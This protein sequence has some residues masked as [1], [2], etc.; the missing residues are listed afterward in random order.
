MR[1]RHLIVFAKPPRIGRAKRRL[2]ADIGATEA[3]RFYRSTLATT[4]RRLGAAPHWRTWLFVDKG[5]AR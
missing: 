5:D 2:A 1:Q 4:L 3:I